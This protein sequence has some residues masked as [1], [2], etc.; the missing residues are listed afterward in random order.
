MRPVPALQ[1]LQEPR[2]VP[3]P[4]LQVLLL[5][6]PVLVPGLQVTLLHLPA[7]APVGNKLETSQLARDLPGGRQRFVGGFQVVEAPLLATF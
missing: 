5:H 6:L 1:V 4:G 7:P 2:V 3:A